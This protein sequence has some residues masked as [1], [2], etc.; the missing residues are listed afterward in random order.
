[1][2][3]EPANTS[4][5][6]ESYFSG[7]VRARMELRQIRYFTM[8]ARELN[9]T[10][11]AGK[12]HLAQPALSRQIKQLEEE[13]GVALLIR[14]KRSV[15]LTE[16]GAAFL[17]EAEAILAQASRVMERMQASP[18]K[19]LKI[20]YV[21]GLFHSLV[22]AAL[23]RFRE[24]SPETAVSLL[25]LSS[26][27]QASLLGSGKLDAGFIGFA[28]E[29]DAAALQKTKIGR[30]NF[31]IALPKGH[32]LARR[33]SVDLRNLAQEFFLLISDQH[34]PGASQVMR[35]ACHAAGFQPRVLQT[36]A[37]GHTILNLVAANCGIALLPAPLRELPHDGVVF[38]APTKPISADLFLA[39][40]SGLD[41]DVLKQLRNCLASRA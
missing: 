1:M 24:V 4:F 31:V 30:C 25:D 2:A 21:W 20:G 32:A 26:L 13:L 41:K 11:A 37:R 28:F 8:V 18:G 22:P 33:S 16:K 6:A 38:R 35:E 15:R 17:A 39:W 5:L 14:D 27:E 19:E 7:M 36:A 23:Q 40:R 29:A 10:R 12:L 3:G 34:F 9:F